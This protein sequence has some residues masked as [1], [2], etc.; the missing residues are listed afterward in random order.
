MTNSNGADT[1]WNHWSTKTLPVWMQA[2][3]LFFSAVVSGA[4]IGWAWRE[5]PWGWCGV[6][7]IALFLWAQSNILN[8]KWLA[9]HAYV[10]GTVSF[11][12]ACP[13]ISGTVGYLAETSP[14]ISLWI[15]IGFQSFQSAGLLLFSVS[16]R[17]LRRQGHVDWIM[18]PFL[19]VGLEQ[20]VPTLFPW[21]PAV[22]LTSDLPMLQVAEFGGVHLVS[23]LVLA[24]ATI[25]AWGANACCNYFLH[26]RWN[27]AEFASWTVVL[28]GI[29]TI[30]YF[31]TVR[32]SELD[33][34]I[35][36][37]TQPSLR[38]GLVQVDTQFVD[39]NQRMIEVTR[40]MQG[41]IDLAIW[42][43]SSL[44]NYSRQLSDFT[45][46]TEV[47]RLSYGDHMRFTPFPDPNCFLLA[48]ADT[49]DSDREDSTP[50]RHFVSAVL[51]D[52][53]EQL[54][55]RN[56][57][58]RLMPYG[59][60]IPGEEYIPWL[61]QLIGSERIITRGDM[62][63][64]IGEVNGFYL[65]VMLCCEDMHSDYVREV[66]ASGVDILVT[67]GNGMAFDAELPLRQHFRISLLRAIEH[68]RYFLRCTSTGVSGLISPTG[69]VLIE[70][71]AREDSATV[72]SIPRVSPQIGTTPFT[73]HG[74][75]WSWYVPV[76]LVMFYFRWHSR[77]KD[78][79]KT[80]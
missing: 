18:A 35:R 16:W 62:A 38:I 75:L 2:V 30:R 77:S 44:G 80:T 76:L 74:W 5:E 26:G 4:L 68:R 1:R 9:A 36:E 27:W 65:G 12:I 40:E 11:A 7:G 39:S 43:E 31:G 24:C 70:L 54:V 6:T 28:I 34:V 72:V 13:W 49:W 10:T 46:P 33:R 45:D 69:R 19:W 52:Q 78:S 20:W 32:I 58:V 66:A 41:Q 17:L 14:T 79:C 50:T 47:Y 23:L 67:L 71:P 61:R 21:P 59:E 56:E 37:S 8:M 53:D 29:L 55:G 60:Y 57:K 73:R 42:P 15:A 64:P 51:I 3:S 63:K 22:M 25:Q 48:G